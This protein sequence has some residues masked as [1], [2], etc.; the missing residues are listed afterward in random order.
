MKMKFYVDEQYIDD[1]IY[2]NDNNI[3]ILRNYS[4]KTEKIIIEQI[5]KQINSPSD[6]KIDLKIKDEVSYYFMNG[7]NFSK[8]EYNYLDETGN[9]IMMIIEITHDMKIELKV[10]SELN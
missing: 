10:L 3:I 8:V 2:N 9:D 7:C 5:K 6:C 4:I 1:I